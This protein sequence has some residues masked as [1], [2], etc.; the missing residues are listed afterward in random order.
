ML[1]EP[2]LRRHDDGAVVP[3]EAFRFLALRPHEGITFAADDDD[4]RAG[5]M[6][7]GL[8]VGADRKFRN[9]H[10]HG[11]LAKLDL[12]VAAPSPS[13]FRG[14]QLELADVG[15]DVGVP[16]LPSPSFI[17]HARSG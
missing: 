9:V 12:N 17:G 8:F 14:K 10:G 13:L 5:T 15:N 1:V 11:I 3:V 2:A 16:D 4:M 6:A 7:M